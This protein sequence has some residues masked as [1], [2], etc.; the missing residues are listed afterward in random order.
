MRVARSCPLR[1]MKGRIEVGDE[2]A[3]EGFMRSELGDA[4]EVKQALAKAE[5]CAKQA[6]L[7]KTFKDRDYYERMRRK[8]LGVADGWR[9]ITEVDKAS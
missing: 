6:A 7:A 9:V 5:E 4:P 8:W 1:S 2:R 3:W